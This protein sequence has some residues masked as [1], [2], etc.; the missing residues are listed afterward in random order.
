M[1]NNW[2]CQFVSLY[3]AWL[4]AKSQ[5]K[6][7]Q[8]CWPGVGFGLAWTSWKPKPMAQAMGLR[9]MFWRNF[10]PQ[11]CSGGSPAS[12]NGCWPLL[13]R[14]DPIWKHSAWYEGK[15][16]CYHCVNY[17][18]CPGDYFTTAMHSQ[19][20]GKL[21]ACLPY[22]FLH[23]HLTGHGSSQAKPEHHYKIGYFNWK[24]QWNAIEWLSYFFYKLF[25][26]VVWTQS[27]FGCNMW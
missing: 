8:K 14:F 5:A 21:Q 27:K 9:P 7:R 2:C 12:R 10:C 16:S 26:T 23:C 24:D 11:H 3:M 18:R 22:N 20:L 17:S 25:P 15:N 1:Q 19:F 4:Q 13:D 6:P